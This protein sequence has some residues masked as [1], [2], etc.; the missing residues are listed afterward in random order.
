MPRTP[1][2]MARIR[3]GGGFISRQSGRRPS[4]VRDHPRRRTHWWKY[5]EENPVG[6]AAYSA[7]DQLSSP[8]G[9]GCQPENWQAVVA[10]S[11][12]NAGLK[13]PLWSASC[14]QGDG[15]MTG[16]LPA[17]ILLC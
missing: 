6:E 14:L 9:N 2:E 4:G 17:P 3:G 1:R 16:P 11:D 8:A 12:M 5:R 13:C 15:T 10:K 7:R